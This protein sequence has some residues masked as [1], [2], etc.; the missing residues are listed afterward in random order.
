M[1]EPIYTLDGV[2]I[3]D[4]DLDETGRFPVPAGYYITLDGV[5]ITAAYPTMYAAAIRLQSM[6]QNG[7]AHTARSNGYG[8]RST[9]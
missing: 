8:I 1:T 7:S 4:R 5:A 3:T 6:A 9:K 2:A